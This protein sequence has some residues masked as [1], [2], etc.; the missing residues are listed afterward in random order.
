MAS[1]ER[2]LGKAPGAFRCVWGISTQRLWP[3]LA[4]PRGTKEYQLDS[5]LWIHMGEN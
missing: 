1:R 3:C 2:P 5:S 4:S